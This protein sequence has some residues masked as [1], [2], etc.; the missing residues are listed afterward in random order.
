MDPLRLR[1]AVEGL[2]NA[3]CGELHVD[4]MDGRFVRDFGLNTRVVESLRG[5]CDL[6]VDVHMM[7]EQPERHLASLAAAGCSS[8][9]IHVESA[10]HVHRTLSR[11][12]ELG[13]SSGIAINPGTALTKLE[14]LFPL[15]DR[16]LLLG[17]E[18]G[19]Q[20]SDLPGAMF[21][22]VRIVRENLD[23]QE[24]RTQLQVE[25]GSSASDTARL[26]DLGADIVVVNAREL[27]EKIDIGASFQIYLAEIES[28]R[29]VA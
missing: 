13:M 8:L 3:G 24:R 25:S 21:E 12:R 7:A 4:M 14:Y 10:N 28:N 26:L 19:S 22:R 18:F 20:A 27:F 6:P 11:I 2:E 1:E 23:Y 15:V 29:T 9:T 17:Q 16:I 5:A